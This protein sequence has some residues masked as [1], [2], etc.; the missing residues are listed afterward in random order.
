MEAMM[1]PKELAERLNVSPHTLRS[2]RV[3]GRGPKW[4]K[5]GGGSNCAIRYPVEDVE[6][7]LLQR[8]EVDNG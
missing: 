4:V 7:W 6:S 3:S 1:T 2:W 8:R 5:L